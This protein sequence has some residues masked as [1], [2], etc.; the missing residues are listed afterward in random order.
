[1]EAAA[2]TQLSLIVQHGPVLKAMADNGKYPDP[3]H[4]FGTVAIH[5]GQ[6]SI[7]A[8]DGVACRQ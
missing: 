3:Y 5:A 8:R 7:R 4:G 6:V 1:M 2:F